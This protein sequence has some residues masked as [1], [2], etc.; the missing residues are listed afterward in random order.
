MSK[1][2]ELNYEDYSVLRKQGQE[3]G[4]VPEWMQ[5]GG[6]QLFMKNYLY[7]AENP[8]EQFQRIANTL[9]EY[10]PV[11]VSPTDKGNFSSKKDFQKYW[12]E[13]FFN[14]LWKAHFCCSTP[15]LAN[16]GTDRGLPVSCSGGILVDDSVSGFY[17][18]AKE[19]ALLTKYGFGTAV[20]V[21]NV[22]HR[23]SEFKGGGK[24]SGALP[25]M[26]MFGDVTS[27]VSQGSN[28]RGAV[29]SYI[30]IEHKDF[31]EIADYLEH[32]PDELNVGWKVSDKFI[33]KLDA[34]VKEAH[35]K[36]RRVMKVKA[37]TGK[38]YF[39]FTDKAE[40]LKPEAYVK[41]NLSVSA[42]QLCNEV[43]LHSDNNHT[44]TCV[45]GWM[46]LSKWKEWKDTDAVFVSTVLLDCVVSYFI[47]IAKDIKG[48]EKAV[49]ATVKGRPIG[50][51]AGGLHTLFQQEMLPFASIEAY[52]LN[53]EIFV[54]IDK[55]SLEASKALAEAEGEPEW[56]KGLG[57]R[58]T[59]RM[60]VAP[61]KSTALIYGGISEGI[62]QDVAFSF[63][64]S[65]AGG[66]VSRVVPVL[67]ELIKS[68][69]LDIEKCIDD[70]NKAKGSVQ[71]VSWLTKKE[72]EVFTTMFEAPHEAVLRQASA[73]QRNID[74]GQSLNVGFDKRHDEEYISRI[75]QIAFKDSH[76]KGMYYVVGKREEAGEEPVIIQQED[77]LAC[78]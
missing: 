21:S 29:A 61:T 36:F 67:L 59:H 27:K 56:C 45:L 57:I 69:G 25:V 60:A 19:V 78:Q 71:D 77:C 4:T 34:G 54:Q 63:I 12:G 28:R 46:N 38:G 58:M 55:Q 40:R 37:I 51:G 73:R 14:V 41:N 35:K 75:H 1:K 6:L 62:N 30:D 66:E 17:D 8:L 42:P 48:L 44:Y 70:V 53:K 5:T 10:A 23:G 3:D 13:K 7:A 26:Q 47:D 64:Q 15:L 24:A 22:R 2:K 43:F 74:Q 11:L 31:Y 50:L 18:A 32:H 76:I 68:K 9:S 65:T 52:I 33:A 72:K 20:D 49:L 39:S 16:T